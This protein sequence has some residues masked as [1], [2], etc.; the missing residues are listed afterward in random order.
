MTQ[1]TPDD[2][3]QLLQRGLY[4]DNLLDV[5]RS[6]AVL[7]ASTSPRRGL[8]TF[9]QLACREVSRVLDGPVLDEQLRQVED[10]FISSAVAFVEHSNIEALNRFGEATHVT[11]Q[12]LSG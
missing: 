6:C 11:L 10:R 12:S 2:I 9:L 8:F 1:V 5:A 7:A 3:I 4:R